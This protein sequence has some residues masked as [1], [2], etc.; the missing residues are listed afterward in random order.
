M[1]LLDSISNLVTPELTRSLSANLGEQPEAIKNG[2]RTGS[3][4]LLG[5]LA[6]KAQNSAFLA[7]VTSLINRSATAMGAAASAGGTSAPAASEASS[8]FLQLLLGNDRA[9]IENRIAQ[10]S[11]IKAASAGTLLSAAAPMV[12]ST[13]ASR[14][15]GAG[16]N[17]GT[18]GALLSAELPQLRGF[19]PSASAGVSGLSPVAST[20][21]APVVQE[22]ES[23]GNKWLLPVL[24]GALVIGGLIWYF[25]RGGSE[26]VKQSANNAADTASQAAATAGDAA[27]S[28]IAA[29]GEFFKRKLPDGVELNIPRLGIEN[30]LIEFIEDPT[31]K[32]D[33]ETWFNF[34]R[35]LFDTGSATLQPSSQEQLQNVASILKAYPS[36]HVRIGGYT[37]NTGDAAS[38]LKLSTDRATTIL[39]DLVTLGVDPS[40]IDGKGY[41][42]DHPVADN[43]TE[44]GRA[45]NRR[46][47]LRVTQ[48]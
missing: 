30:K 2:L 13:L 31:K 46:I 48:K 6:N 34:D 4:M 18:L 1:S 16:M 28:S 11:G 3:A 32:A 41:G 19:I 5:M 20:V 44:A 39:N 45:L 43:G 8:S 10:A 42:E 38:N 12:M 17:S 14:F 40:H 15:S 47:S 33:K 37:D 23:S 24:L 35:L 7:H 26:T 36:V 29:L 21:R 22:T 25:M 27:K 9:E